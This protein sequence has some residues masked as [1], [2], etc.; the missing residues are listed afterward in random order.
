MPEAH[1]VNQ[2][3]TRWFLEELCRRL[4]ERTVHILWKAVTGMKHRPTGSLRLGRTGL[5][6][7]TVNYTQVH[8]CF[9]WANVSQSRAWAAL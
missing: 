4:N 2:I 6:A 9:I 3:I 8:L 5:S 7:A 1:T